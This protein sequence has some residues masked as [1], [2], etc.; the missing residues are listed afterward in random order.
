MIQVTERAADILKDLLEGSPASDD[1]ALRL[2]QTG[3]GQFGLQLDEP[4]EGDQVVKKDDRLVLLVEP[5][6]STA[7]DGATLDI[8]GEQ[9]GAG[10][11]I[12]MPEEPSANGSTA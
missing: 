7:L 2:A 1:Q 8:T 12:Q 4:R 5:P 9:E 6:V 3:P 11:T 10:L